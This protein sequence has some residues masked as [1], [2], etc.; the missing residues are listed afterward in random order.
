MRLRYLGSSGPKTMLE[1]TKLR[2]ASTRNGKIESN[3][4]MTIWTPRKYLKNWSSCRSWPIKFCLSQPQIFLKYPEC[5]NQLMSTPKNSV[6]TSPFT[7]WMPDLLRSPLLAVDPKIFPR[8]DPCPIWCRI[9]WIISKMAVEL[10]KIG[11]KFCVKLGIM[12]SVEPAQ[13]KN[14]KFEISSWSPRMAT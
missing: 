2:D 9:A 1:R 13:Q 14:K 12:Q 6:C 8:P 5:I 4:T 3:T 11:L 10:T 7:R